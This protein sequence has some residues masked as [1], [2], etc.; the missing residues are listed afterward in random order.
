M[1]WYKG[2]RCR[3]WNDTKVPV[4]N[5]LATLNL[6]SKVTKLGD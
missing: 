5:Q 3:L 6:L 2:W 1:E 4:G